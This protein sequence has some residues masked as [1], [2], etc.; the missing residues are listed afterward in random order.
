MLLRRKVYAI[1]MAQLIIT[2]GFIAL[3]VFAPNVQC[4]S[5][6]HPEIMWIAFAI[7]MVLLIVLAC[8]DDFRRRWPLN[9]ILLGLFTICE[10]LILGTIASFYE[11][12]LKLFIQHLFRRINIFIYFKRIVSDFLAERRSV[13]R[14]RNLHSCLSLYHHTQSAN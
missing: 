14:S 13:D 7:S 10:G 5:K 8:F 6:N 9:I 4:Y 12:K 2:V 1:L 11:V 3:F